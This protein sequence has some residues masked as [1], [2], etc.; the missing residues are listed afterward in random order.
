MLAAVAAWPA[1]AIAGSGTIF[2]AVVLSAEPLDASRSA[3]LG[4]TAALVPVVD[5]PVVP[6]VVVPVALVW[7][8]LVVLL[9]V[10]AVLLLATGI[11]TSG[12]ACG[13]VVASFRQPRITL[14]WLI[15]S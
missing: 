12:S 4:D 9:A 2:D 11:R 6:V 7:P 13:P 10:L 5:P 14:Y 15:S 3:G 1:V 8:V